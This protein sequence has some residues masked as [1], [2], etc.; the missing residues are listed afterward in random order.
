[1]TRRTNTSEKWTAKGKAMRDRI[2]ET[3]A[4]LASRRGANA[5]SLDEVRQQAGASKSQLYHYFADRD[6]FLR[7]IVAFQGV[8]VIAAQ[9]PELGRIATMESLRNWRDKLAAFAETHG[10]SGGCPLG[11]FANELALH[12]A[13]M[14]AAFIEGFDAWATELERGFAAMRAHGALAPGADPKQLAAL[15][16]SAIQG[17]LL[18]AKL[19][20]STK[21][22]VQSL[23]QLIDMLERDRNAF[24]GGP[25]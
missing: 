23:D 17:G 25:T 13:D 20:G 18:F 8:Q 16:L 1:M 3:G 24:D 21:K 6:D 2:V 14:R 4:E 9:H 11:S 5:T 22:L 12:G 15:F 7:E 19:E 10:R